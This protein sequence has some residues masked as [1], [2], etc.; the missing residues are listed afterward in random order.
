MFKTKS[1]K[2]DMNKDLR[3]K[4]TTSI[5]LVYDINKSVVYEQKGTDVIPTIIAVVVILLLVA[6]VV[7]TIIKFTYK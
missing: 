7:I 5:T 3:K 1:E 4:S 2:K 6:L